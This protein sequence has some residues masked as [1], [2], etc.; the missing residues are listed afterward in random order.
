MEENRL[1]PIN[2]ISLATPPGSVIRV[3]VLTTVIDGDQMRLYLEDD[4]GKIRAV[5]SSGRGVMNL[6]DLV[7]ASFRPQVQW[8]GRTSGLVGTECLVT[9]LKVTTDRSDMH[10]PSASEFS[11]ELTEDTTFK[12]LRMVERRYNFQPIAELQNNRDLVDVLG[13]I[14]SVKEINPFTSSRDIILV[15]SSRGVVVL[16]LWREQAEQFCPEVGSVLAVQLAYTWTYYDFNLTTSEWTSLELNPE[17]PEAAALTEWYEHEG[18]SMGD[19][20]VIS[21]AFEIRTG[22][23]LW[24]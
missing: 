15:D 21:K 8:T 20:I 1:I 7:G 23:A 12:P 6:M 13:I 11:L 9:G 19:P 17:I 18:Q 5:G 16:T 14:R 2:E 22:E 3:R 10:F 24:N 4:S